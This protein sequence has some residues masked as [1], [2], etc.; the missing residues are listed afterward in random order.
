MRFFVAALTGGVFTAGGPPSRAA[1]APWRI[2]FGFDVIDDRLPRRDLTR[3]EC[4][5]TLG[6]FRFFAE[7][8]EFIIERAH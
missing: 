4:R 5:A 3:A 7:E 6:L 2:L 1:A 8:P